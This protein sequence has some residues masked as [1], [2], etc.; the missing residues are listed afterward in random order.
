MHAATAD[1]VPPLPTRLKPFACLYRQGLNL[2]SQAR[3]G[4]PSA[5]TLF[6]GRQCIGAPPPVD[7]G[8]VERRQTSS[9]FDRESDVR[10]SRVPPPHS[11]VP[12]NFRAAARRPLTANMP[13]H[14]SPG[15]T[16][17]TRRCWPCP[18]LHDSDLPPKKWTR[19]WGNRVQYHGG[20]R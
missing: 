12:R 15:R 7:R 19:K 6:I 1:V 11:N 10:S 3:G 18:A 9:L 20:G 8:R 4:H 13:T 5:N 2:S 16:R 17:L 14:E